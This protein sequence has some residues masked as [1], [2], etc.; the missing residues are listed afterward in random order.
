MALLNIDGKK[1]QV[2]VFG[3]LA[4]AYDSNV[5]AQSHGVGDY[6]SDLSV[7]M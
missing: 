5:F 3:E 7:G 1:N 2:Y 4:L 6:S